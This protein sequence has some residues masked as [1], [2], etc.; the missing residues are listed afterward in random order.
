MKRS[1]FFCGMT[2]IL[3]PS[4]LGLLGKRLDYLVPKL[5]MTGATVVTRPVKFG[6]FDL[7]VIRDNFNYKVYT[8]IYG[9]IYF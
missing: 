8:T 2:G 3:H 5:N 9:T 6:A 4:G 1:L 7:G